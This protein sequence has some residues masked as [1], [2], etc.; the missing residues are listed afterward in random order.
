MGSLLLVSSSVVTWNNY[1]AYVFFSFN[2]LSFAVAMMAVKNQ[3]SS[4]RTQL[5]E[6]FWV[7]HI[8]YGSLEERVEALAAWCK[9]L[10]AFF[11]DKINW[12]WDDL[13]SG[14]DFRNSAH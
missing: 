11:A 3:F 4:A 8:H 9:Q 7:A 5:A 6:L 10:A 2:K 12:T 14:L 1:V 13:G